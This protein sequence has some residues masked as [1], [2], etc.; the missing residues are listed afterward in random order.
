MLKV[1][2]VEDDK[3][4]IDEYSDESF[5]ELFG[6][7]I[8]PT[9]FEEAY[10][11]TKD[12][13]EYDFV[14]IDIDLR[15]FTDFNE[16]CASDVK[17]DILFEEREDKS[18]T[19]AE[20]AGLVIFTKLLESGF[21]KERVVFLT[22]NAGS[23]HNTYDI[24]KK[25]FNAALMTLPEHIVKSDDAPEKLSQKLKNKINNY[26]TLRREI[27][28]GCEYLKYLSKDGENIQINNYTENKLELIEIENYLDTLSKFL[29][30]NKPDDL[31]ATY[32][33]FL[34]TLLHE[35][36]T[37]VRYTPIIGIKI[38]DIGVFIAIMKMTRNWI[39]HDNLLEK[40]N[41][42]IVSY[43]F[44]LNMRAMFILSDTVLDYEDKILSS[45]L[46]KQEELGN[47][48][49]KES[50]LEKINYSDEKVNDILSSIKI[51]E[52]DKIKNKGK[53]TKDS[54]Y[55]NDKINFLYN[56]KTTIDYK[57]LLLQ[58]FLVAHKN[59]DWL[60]LENLLN[61]DKFSP[62]LARHIYNGNF[63][64]GE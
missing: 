34:R 48:I 62:T 56:K 19:F 22:A 28:E 42:E 4:N 5:E 20:Q 11:Y 50:Y 3:D 17:T 61:L 40:F 55:F 51:T 26:L 25:H 31:N 10:E 64:L 52:K 47:E 49:K 8:V 58:C 27:I 36:D 6:E 60:G 41:T 18:K 7:P 37:S 45:I 12:S 29:P 13:L 2:W 30:I 32:R 44:L 57:V 14:I 53:G 15:R 63:E 59:S 33:I 24:F 39:S 16:K 54:D 9:S 38:Y 23:E 35:W 21:P 43:L 1:L 46:E